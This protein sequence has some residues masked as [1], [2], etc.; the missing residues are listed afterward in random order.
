MKFSKKEIELLVLLVKSEKPLPPK[1]VAVAL[2]VDYANIYKYLYRLE[3]KG[4]VDRDEFGKV[5]LS[6]TPQAESFKRLYYAHPSSPFDRILTGRKTELLLNLNQTPKTA[7]E[8]KRTTKISI[9]NIY[10]YLNEFTKLGVVRRITGKKPPRGTHRYIFNE[11]LWGDLKTLIN[12]LSTTEG[13][14]KTPKGSILIKDYGNSILFKSIR[15]Q[16][17]TPTS[18]S[19]YDKY[20][21]GLFFM[22]TSNYYTLPKRNLSI[23]D[24]FIHSLDSADDISHR[25]YCII[26]FIINK[27]KLSGVRHPMITDIKNV[28]KGKRVNGFP[29]HEEVMD[30]VSVYVI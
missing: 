26:F 14:K 27:R 23:I 22:S 10:D 1:D 11:I 29:T 28:L 17:A 25:L 5:L 18:F 16:D 13:V 6:I 30:R 4:L 3:E 19:V 21:V 2:D 8:L 15:R 20:G 9:S 24:V 12:H 7:N